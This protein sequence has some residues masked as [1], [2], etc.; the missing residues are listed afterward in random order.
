MDGGLVRIVL[1]ETHWRDER[2]L[3]LLLAQAGLQLAHASGL[4]P[5]WA[6]H[7]VWGWRA[8]ER[9]SKA[10]CC[11]LSLRALLPLNFCGVVPLGL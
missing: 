1:A 7:R 11:F 8:R 6:R 9:H 2:F 4:G 10:R 5:L 3:V